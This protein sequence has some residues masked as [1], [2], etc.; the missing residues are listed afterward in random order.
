MVVAFSV[1]LELDWKQIHV[2]ILVQELGHSCQVL[3]G[4]A[5][6]IHDRQQLPQRHGELCGHP[7]L[8][9]DLAPLLLHFLARL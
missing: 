2:S 9:A 4:M 1:Y 8:G 7:T 3:V 6:D 5:D